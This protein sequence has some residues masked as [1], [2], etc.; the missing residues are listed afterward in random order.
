MEHKELV[1]R[2]AAV[3]RRIYNLCLDSK[4]VRE[5]AWILT[6]EKV[7]TPSGKTANGAF[8]PS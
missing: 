4:S 8:R 3:V 6:A 2:E 5:I 7:L 1:W